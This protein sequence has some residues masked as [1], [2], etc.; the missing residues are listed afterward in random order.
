MKPLGY[1]Y[2]DWILTNFGATF[3]S[4]GII[5]PEVSR[6][7]SSEHFPS[8]CAKVRPNVVGLTDGF[9]LTDMMVNAAIGRYDGNVYDNYFETVKSLNPPE[10]T[11]APYSKALED[12]LNRPD[13]EVRQRG[14]NQ[15]KLL[16]SCPVNDLYIKTKLNQVLIIWL[17]FL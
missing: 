6:K 13:L 7:I 10:N 11:K 2:A 4:Y 17:V 9:N 15:T 12:M 3:L 14:E 1:L 5:S 16:K 8:M